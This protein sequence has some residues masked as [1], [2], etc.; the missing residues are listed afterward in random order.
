MSEASSTQW[1]CFLCWKWNDDWDQNQHIQ[2]THCMCCQRERTFVPKSVII[3]DRAKPLALHGISNIQ[4][5]YRVEQL[6]TLTEMG[7]DLT[8]T[9]NVG[10]TI[11]LPLRLD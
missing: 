3:P 11:D 9:A 10:T 8:S 2:T 6:K 4:H 5:P 1:K 7:L